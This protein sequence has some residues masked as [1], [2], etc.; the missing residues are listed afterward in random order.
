MKLITKLPTRSGGFAA[1]RKK[2][3]AMPLIY[4][5]LCDES[6][7]A[8]EYAPIAAGISLAI[9]SAVNGLGTTLRNKFTSV[10]TSLR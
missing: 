5:F 8:I 7:A 3:L 1:R 2:G 10:N 9:I 6:G 4:K